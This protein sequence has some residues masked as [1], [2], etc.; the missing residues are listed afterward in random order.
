MKDEMRTVMAYACRFR[1]GERV[2][3]C[4]GTILKH[5]QRCYK[6]P[7]NKACP[8]C[9]CNQKEH[10]DYGGVYY[11]CD[12]GVKSD[13]NDKFIVNCSSF[14]QPKEGGKND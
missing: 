11:V 1:C 3:T 8:A 5:E 10:G 12:K 7:K 13:D 4:A 14:E 2:T 9:Q 6:N